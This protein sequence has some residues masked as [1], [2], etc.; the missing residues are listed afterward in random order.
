MK[1]YVLRI[2]AIAVCFLLC[3]ASAGILTTPARPP[4]KDLYDLSLAWQGETMPANWTYDDKGWSVFAREGDAVHPLSPDGRGG[5][6]GLD[7]PGQTCY[8]SRVLTENVKDPALW[9]GDSDGCLAVFLD[10][11]L[12]YTESPDAGSQIGKMCLPLRSCEWVEPVVVTLPA[13]YLGKTLTIAQG[14]SPD[15]AVDGLPRLRPASVLLSCGF[16]YERNLIS[17]S[18][19]TAIPATI[20]FIMSV[21]LMA[22]FCWQVFHGK[23]DVG[24]ICAAVAAALWMISRMALTSFGHYT[25]FNQLSIDVVLFCRDLSRIAM[26]AFLCSRAT[27]NRHV[28][29]GAMTVLDC[30]AMAFY[31]LYQQANWYPFDA[32]ELM[33]VIALLEMLLA[34]VLGFVEWKKTGSPFYHLFIPLTG[35][36]FASYAAAVCFTPY[37]RRSALNQ[38]SYSVPRSLLHPFTVLMMAAAIAAAVTVAVRREIE[39]RMEARLLTQRQDLVRASYQAVCTHQEQVMILRHDMKKHFRMLR[40]MTNEP[41][42]AAYLDELIGENEKIRPVIQSGNDMLDIILNGKMTTA[43]D[44]GISI[45]ILRSHAPEVLPLSGRELCSLF[46]N[47]MDNAIAGAQASGAEHPSIQLDLHVKSDFFVFSCKNSAGPGQVRPQEHQESVPRHG[48]GLKIIRNISQKYGD[49]LETE[50]G[51]DYY[52]VTVA[53]PLTRPGNV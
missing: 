36:A 43:V 8:F 49:L 15:A 4:V 23:P 38:L 31:L 41:Q 42:V 10:E 30:A 14:T 1:K 9:L 12:L 35:I 18:F 20:L 27:G 2:F 52:K 29:L 40:S 3:A 7:F 50:S 17:E 37:L 16:A 39:R 25:Y 19:R 48:L 44:A 32:V 5:F 33:A 34:L 46:M 28:A 6:T 51:H 11:T 24:L 13:D 26:L 45:E 53:I 21:F 47:V 22:L